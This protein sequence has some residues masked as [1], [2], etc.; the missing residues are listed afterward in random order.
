MIHNR[1]VE[2]RFLPEA[3]VSIPCYLYSSPDPS[4]LHN[5]SLCPHFLFSIFE[6]QTSQSFWASDVGLSLIRVTAP[7][8]Q[9]LVK[10]RR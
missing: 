8:L 10:P 4:D 3:V 2:L 6:H 1:M 7:S 5:Q 9:D